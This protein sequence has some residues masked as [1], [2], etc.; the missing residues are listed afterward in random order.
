MEKPNTADNWSESKDSLGTPGS[1]NSVAPLSIDGA[2]DGD[3][4]FTPPFPDKNDNV[5]AEVPIKNVGLND[6]KGILTATVGGSVVG[7]KA[8]SALAPE[9]DKIYYLSI[10]ALPSGRHNVAFELEVAG[11][12]DIT[13]NTAY[14]KLGISYDPGIIQI[15]EFFSDP[16][17]G[18]SEFIELV[19]ARSVVIDGW[20][21]RDNSSTRLL[22]I[23]YI[24]KDDYIVLAG[25]SSLITESDPAAIYL[26]PYGG[27]PTLNNS[28]DNIYLVD[29][30][31]TIIDSL[32][33]GT[34]WPVIADSSTEK[35]NPFLSSN[36]PLNWK[37]SIDPLGMTPGKVNSNYLN[38]YDG[39]IIADSINI[40]PKYPRPSDPYQI[41]VP[42]TNHG[43]ESISGILNI[44]D[45]NNISV[46]SSAVTNL[47]RRDTNNIVFE[48]P[49]LTSGIHPLSFRLDIN[50]DGNTTDNSAVDTVFIS[51]TFG[52]VLI[53][54]FLP[55]PNSTQA[56]FVELIA[57][58]DINFHGW[59]IADATNDVNLFSAGKIE[60]ETF[61]VLSADNAF[62]SIIPPEAEYIQVDDF[63]SLNNYGDAIYLHD[64]TGAIIDSLIY[65]TWW[66]L[67]TGVS[68]E[69]IHPQLISSD[70]TAWLLS[71]DT[72]G[73]TPGRTNSV[74]ANESDGAI[75][76]G[77]IYS[78]P[79]YPDKGTEFQLIIPVHNNGLQTISGI[80]AVE[81]AG[82]ELS[83]YAISNINAGDTLNCIINISPMRSGIHPIEIILDVDSD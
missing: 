64:F 52:D 70:S 36:D 28:G 53:N 3:I 30:N 19:A 35:L 24:E 62:S 23:T 54:E 79:E 20:N 78:V 44:F 9:D 39:E 48:L 46:A 43:S 7:S 75:L 42:I 68:T 14:K 16:S 18:Q 73:M 8:V 25:D 27:L 51:Y 13:N 1:K 37:V 22:P 33:Y 15:N 31:H 32:E 21:I 11:D 50:E 10:S 49:P 12:G 71:I 60:A 69:K 4:N 40:N 2:I 56:E 45:E 81:Q 38:N 83:N 74:V 82:I 41:I 57:N 5:V 34:G 65:T 77:G 67:E 59:G 47:A 6:I 26:I 63:P 66:E 72:T 58:S 76:P 17:D 61:I 29:M 55:G 80:I